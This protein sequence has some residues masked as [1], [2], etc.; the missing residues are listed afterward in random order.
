M[1][2]NKFSQRKKIAI[3]YH[4]FRS[5]L[6]KKVT[7][8]CYIDTA[9]QTANI[10]NKPLKKALFIYLQKKYLDCYLKSDSFASTL[11]CLR[12]QRKTQN[13]NTRKW[14]DLSGSSYF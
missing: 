12:I 4:N 8:I 2:F 10:F 6:Q 9:E 3:E 1:Y 14:F 13:H 11:G 7:Q 5:F